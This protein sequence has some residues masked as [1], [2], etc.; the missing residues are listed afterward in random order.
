MV[1]A[2]V[3]PIY[4]LT[5]MC[6]EDLEKLW[7]ELSKISPDIREQMETMLYAG[8]M[9][10]HEADIEAYRKDENLLLPT[11]MDYS[12]R[13]ACLTKF[14]RSSSRLNSTT[15]GEAARIPGNLPLWL[16]CS[17]M[18]RSLPKG[19]SKLEY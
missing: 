17:A 9:D 6:R 10:R 7:P 3:F 2:G 5:L 13:V 15:L 1:F 12:G 4:F 18:S 16:P 8:Y 14:A 19:K 11:D